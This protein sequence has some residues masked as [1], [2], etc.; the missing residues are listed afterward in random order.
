MARVLK[1]KSHH[2][3]DGVAREHARLNRDFVFRVDMHTPARAGVLAL[4]VFAHADK[5]DVFGSFA[6]ERSL[7]PGQ[8]SNRAEI[9]VLLETFANRQEQALQRDMVCRE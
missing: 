6:F 2:A 8:E 1:T 4:R 9:D 5:V 7:Q 3:F